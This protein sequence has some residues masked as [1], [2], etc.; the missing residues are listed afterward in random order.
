MKITHVMMALLLVLAG[1]VVWK[2]AQPPAGDDVAV[3]TPAAGKAA[4]S[5]PM[6]LPPVLEESDVAPVVG[7]ADGSLKRESE[8]RV[9]AARSVADHASSGSTA[10]LG[11]Y[12]AAVP[13]DQIRPTQ[14]P[15]V[16]REGYPDAED[17]PVRRPAED[18]VSTFS[19][20]VDTAS[21]ANVRRQLNQGRLPRHESVRAEEIINYFDYAY[22]M[23]E[24]DE[25][26]AVYTEIGPSPWHPQ[27]RLLHIGIQG[28][29][30]NAAD[31]P[32]ANLVF[33]VDVS[34]SMRSPDKLD[35]LK[36]SLRL[37]VGQLRP[38][39]HVSMVVYAGAAG[40]VLEP[41]P[42]DQR[43]TILRALDQLQ[44]GGSTNGGQGIELA[45]A[46]AEQHLVEEGVN[47]V[48][49]ATD[50]D[51]NV[52]TV[53]HDALEQLIERKREAGVALTVLG[54][55]QGNYQDGL[56]QRLAQKGNG[57]AAYV[58][59]LNEARKVLVDELAATLEII[60]QDVKI[61]VEF[62]PAVVAEY[63]LIGY[64]TRQLARED[65]N[66]DRVDAG[67]IGAGHTVTALY[68]LALVGEDGAQVDPLRYAIPDGRG[69]FLGRPVTD[70]IA[71]LRLRYKRPGQ[72]R[73]ELIERPLPHAAL[74]ERL[75]DTSED[76][77]F[78][79]AT[80][81]YAQLL[82]GARYTGEMQLADVLALAREARGADPFGYRGE[83]LTL[84]AS[85]DALSSVQQT[86][87]R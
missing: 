45:Y 61:Q 9:R 60:A 43:A 36:A 51:F 34:G 23:P 13:A 6:R 27:R 17:N 14:H 74:R 57:N 67:D 31:L 5:E 8:L 21:Y 68:E 42:G 56:M 65:F 29:V 19:I 35:L 48:I 71:H 86:S 3:T 63:R 87:R 11:A 64:E 83:F 77:R 24:A 73:S 18:P 25:P 4:V 20:D 79:A 85:A 69:R 39:D 82:S 62:N 2:Q 38:Q 1:A 58:D 49:L 26:F 46:L 41:T 53:S 40:V 81:A 10:S 28:A 37:L 55:G 12:L 33:L 32:P 44:A 50:G 76:F 52:G 66:N 72:K 78:S 80:A 16:D 54:F 84:V 30:R 22:P 7:V 59:T 75:A 47:R 15:G 70:E